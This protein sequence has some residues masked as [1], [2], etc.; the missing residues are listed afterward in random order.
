MLLVSLPKRE[1]RTVLDEIRGGLIVSCQPVVGGPMDRPDIV[2]A[3][4]LA[5]LDG[6]ASA[7]RIEGRDNIIHVR[8]KT[9]APII[10]LIKRDLSDSAVRITPLLTDIAE[11]VD[12]GAD[13]I[14]FD[15][16]NRPRPHPMESLL[17]AV[18]A[19]NA[20]AMADCSAFDEGAHALQ[21]GAD[22]IGTTLS[23]YTEGQ[24]PEG[25]DLELISALAAVSPHIVAEGRYRTTEQAADA[26]RRGAFAVVVGSAIT[27]TEHI[28]NWFKTAVNDADCD[29]K[30][31][32]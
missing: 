18:H 16:T 23:G 11:L 27:R 24:E 8:P 25:P 3:F 9:K 14:A 29:G 31:A 17:E 10:G 7:L 6:G 30:I 26:I 32:R 28:T 5:A 19:S 15:A 22:L 2:A 21:L 1:K 4:C 20:I 12:A 13:I